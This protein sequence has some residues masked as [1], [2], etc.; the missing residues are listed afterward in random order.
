MA[1]KD[2]VELSKNWFD[3]QAPVYD[4]KNVIIYSKYGKI[5]CQNIRDYLKDK[6]YKKLT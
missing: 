4:E 2:Y 6:E 5:S 1:K 3:K